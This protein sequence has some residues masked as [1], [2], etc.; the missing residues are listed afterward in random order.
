MSL[1]TLYLDDD[2]LVPALECSIRCDGCKFWERLPADR[3]RGVC[4]QHGGVQTGNDGPS[5]CEVLT[6]EDAWCV[7]CEFSTEGLEAAIRDYQDQADNEPARYPH[8]PFA[9][10]SGWLPRDTTVEERHPWR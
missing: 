4:A 3:K 2:H 8:D 10:T 9:A 7:Y 1:P 5:R 6:P